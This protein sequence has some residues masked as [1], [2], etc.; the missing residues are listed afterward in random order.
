MKG[1]G[2]QLFTALKRASELY[3][4]GRAAEAAR[5]PGQESGQE[6]EQQIDKGQ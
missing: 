3:R 2:G 1:A 4:K 5:Q 6:S